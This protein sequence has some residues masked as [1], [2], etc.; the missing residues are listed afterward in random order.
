MKKLSFTLVLFAL[1]SLVLAEDE[2]KEDKSISYHVGI[3][4]G[5]QTKSNISDLDYDEFIKAFKVAYEGD[6]PHEKIVASN[7]AIQQYVKEQKKIKGDAALKKGE[8]FL[9]KNAKRKGV[10]T[11]DSGLQYEVLKKG[12]GDKPSATDKVSVNYRGTLI[13]GKEFDSSFK[14]GKPAEFALNR[15]VKGWTEGIQLMS[16][17][18]KYK[19]FIP[20]ALGYGERG[21]GANI[22][23]N[24][25]LIF[26][27]ELLSVV[28]K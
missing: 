2:K 22:G 19:F 13:D 17:G 6:I 3:L 20:A 10:I 16:P 27:V 21:A 26:E 12:K 8:A 28:G 25:T 24:E 14:R 7:T 5:K 11:T 4:M 1:S 15:V 23:P 9:T 18:A